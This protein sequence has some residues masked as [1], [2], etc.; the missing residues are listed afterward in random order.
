VQT[1][2]SHCVVA[3][4]YNRRG[5]GVGCFSNISKLLVVGQ[6]FADSDETRKNCHVVNEFCNKVVSGG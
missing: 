1:N 3:Q 5:D 6:N 4:I 2:N